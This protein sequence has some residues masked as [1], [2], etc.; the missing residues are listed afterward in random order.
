MCIFMMLRIVNLIIN[1]V[2]DMNQKASA[3]TFIHPVSFS[4]A[5]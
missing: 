3:V 5:L 4:T 2:S 1:L